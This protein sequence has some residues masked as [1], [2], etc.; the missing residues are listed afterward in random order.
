MQATK[1]VGSRITTTSESTGKAIAC[2]VTWKSNTA[3]VDTEA[4]GAGSSTLQSNT[5]DSAY[6]EWHLDQPLLQNWGFSVSLLSCPAHH[7]RLKSSPLGADLKRAGA[8][9]AAEAPGKLG[10]EDSIHSS[11]LPFSHC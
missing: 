2:A 7:R 11:T 8:A 10:T 6:L 1:I 5:N 9:A 3:P 4:A